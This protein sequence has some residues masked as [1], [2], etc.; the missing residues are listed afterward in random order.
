MKVGVVEAARVEVVTPNAETADVCCDCEDEEGVDDLAKENAGVIVAEEAE[1]LV[2]PKL[3]KELVVVEEAAAV[4]GAAAGI[5]VVVEELTPKAGNVGVEEAGDDACAK[6]V[7]DAVGVEAPV[8]VTDE[9]RDPVGVPNPDAAGLAGV[10]APEVVLAVEDEGA[11]L[12]PKEDP[13][14]KLDNDEGAEEERV[15]DEEL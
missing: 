9:K 8:V 11:V 12:N 6:V 2:T 7:V 1:V 4:A 13:N 3:G 10:A 14:E 5:V 15:V